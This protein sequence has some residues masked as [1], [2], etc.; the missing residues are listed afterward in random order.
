[1]SSRTGA[2]LPLRTNDV[3]IFEDDKPNSPL[4]KLENVAVLPSES[5]S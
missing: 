5:V 4:A 1:M 3:I 2:E